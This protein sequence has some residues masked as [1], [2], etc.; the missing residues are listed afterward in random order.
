M[1]TAYMD[2]KGPRVDKT[3]LKMGSKLGNFILPDFKTF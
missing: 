1:I 2:M 3:I